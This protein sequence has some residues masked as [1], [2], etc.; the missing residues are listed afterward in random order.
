MAYSVQSYSAQ[1][2]S[3]HRKHSYTENA[4]STRADVSAKSRLRIMD[5]LFVLVISGLA[6]AVSGV[7]V[8]KYVAVTELNYLRQELQKDITM[9]KE[10]NTQMEMKIAEM[11]SPERIY[12]IAINE[13]GMTTASPEKVKIVNT[14]RV[15]EVD[16]DY[17]KDE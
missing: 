1:S 9:Y 10:A 16:S 17:G 6:I 5:K 14:V 3:I 13:I 7:L 2:T 8:S 11:S 12:D 4:V 15:A